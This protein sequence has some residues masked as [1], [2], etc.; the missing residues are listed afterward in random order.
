MT[1]LAHGLHGGKK[2]FVSDSRDWLWAD[3]RASLKAAGKLPTIPADHWGHGNTYKD[4]LMLANGPDPTAPGKA[5]EGAG[6]CVWSSAAHQT[7]EALTDATYTPEEVAAVGKLFDGST[8]ISDYSAA[9]GYNPETGEGDNGTEIRAALTYR[10]T[11]GIV[12]TAGNR[13]KIGPFVSIEPGNLEHLLE[14]LYFFEASAMGFRVQQAQ[15]DAFNQAEQEGKTPIWDYVAGSPEVGG[16]D[17]PLV[18]HPDATNYAAISWAK[19]VIVTPA[20]ISNQCDELWVC[21]TPERISK[22]TGKSYELATAAQL[23]E[24]LHLVASKAVAA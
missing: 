12:D 20:L 18:G 21:I 13:H 11:T 14:A 22:V 6:C 23:E 15:M 1:E 2:P 5:T 9:T 4:W 17:V 19:R 16:H 8:T 3:F 7:M 10:Q 24:Y